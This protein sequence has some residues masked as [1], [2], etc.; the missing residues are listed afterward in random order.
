MP[1]KSDEV[2]SFPSASLNYTRE[3]T[4]WYTSYNGGF[5]YFSIEGKDR[6]EING[7]DRSA[8]IVRNSWLGQENW[9]HKA[10][11]GMD[12][13]GNEK[14][15]LSLYG[16]ASAFSNEQEGRIEISGSE[17]DS[18]P[19]VYSMIKD[20]ADRNRSA[21]G[22]FYYRHLFRPGSEL[23]L[24]SSYYLLRAYSGTDLTDPGREVR[25][26]NRAEP[27][28]DEVQVRAH[29]SSG[30]ND[31]I[32]VE[33]GLEQQFNLMRDALFTSFSYGERV[34]AGY[35]QGTFKGDRFTANT[36]LRAEYIRVRYSD[37]RD[38]RRFFLLPQFD[39][40]YTFNQKN[41]LRISYVKKVNRPE[42]H[43]LNPNPYAADP[44]TLQQGNPDL[45]PEVTRE[46]MAMHSLS[47]RE[48]YLSAGLFFRQ[49]NGVIEELTQLSGQASFHL[50][51]QN[52]GDR[53][54]AGVKVLGSMNLHDRFSI[55]PHLELSCVSTRG[56][57]LAVDEGVEDQSE[58]EFRGRISAVWAIR[59][60]LSL[61]ASLQGQ[62]TT[63]GIQRAYRE[64]ALYFINIDKVFF[65]RL[66]VG[67]TSAIPFMRSFTYQGYDLSGRHF[68]ETSEDNIL[69]SAVPVWIRLKY[70]FASG[71]RTRR[72][73]RDKVFKEERVKKGF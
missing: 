43:Q 39:L 48:N 12:H 34:S 49:Q 73:E 29:F 15:Q 60:D 72:L 31:R 7:G 18:T 16:F 5:S 23:I 30:I 4:T 20:D 24:E 66:K 1:T 56:N 14:N 44:F 65:D 32:S 37:V 52:L 9:S 26:S 69:M 19:S 47:F 21:Y 51:E 61:S 59:D 36:G 71:E 55:Q 53:I 3:K 33:T 64:G 10:H 50:Q 68:T 67:I 22:S 41:N 35:L 63:R 54:Y 38:Q 6:K 40:K 17:G 27:G 46:I 8:E 57:A 25:V 62:S 58:M 42:M 11:F 2:F 45:F 28:R 70:S 13:F